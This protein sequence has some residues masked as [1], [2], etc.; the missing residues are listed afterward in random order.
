MGEQLRLEVH[1]EG[2]VQGV[3]MR[4]FV[5]QQ[6]MSLGITGRVRN[7]QDGRVEVIA[8][9]END[10]LNELLEKLKNSPVGRVVNVDFSWDKPSL[11]FPDFHIER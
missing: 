10:R 6:A 3:G 9:G 8:E 7:L 11:A 5:R 4:Y 1:L 2:Q